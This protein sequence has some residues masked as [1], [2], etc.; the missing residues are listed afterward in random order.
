MRSKAVCVAF[1]FFETSFDS[2][3]SFTCDVLNAEPGLEQCR[4]Q[5]RCAADEKQAVGDIVLLGEVLQ[6]L[7]CQDGR[8][9]SS[10]D[11]VATPPRVDHVT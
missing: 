8:E 3:P 4:R 2:V 10:P 9:A 11:R 1:E 6:E 7:L 5:P